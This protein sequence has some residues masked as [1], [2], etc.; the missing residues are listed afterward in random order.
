M[1]KDLRNVRNIMWLVILN[2]KNGV[3]REQVLHV[4]SSLNIQHFACN[5]PWALESSLLGSIKTLVHSCVFFCVPGMIYSSLEDVLVC[6]Q[7]LVSFCTTFHDKRCCCNHCKFLHKVAL[8]KNRT[9]K[10]YLW[11]MSLYGYF[12][13]VWPLLMGNESRKEPVNWWVL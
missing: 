3:F 12:Q 9:W 2:K 1:P 13:K 4:G 5:M 10:C 11:E 6:K 7:G 8:S